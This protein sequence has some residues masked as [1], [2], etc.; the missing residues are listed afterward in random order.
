[1]NFC[2]KCGAKVVDE[3]DKFCGKCG[4]SLEPEKKEGEVGK[5]ATLEVKPEEIKEGESILID[6]SPEEI[7][8]TAYEKGFKHEEAVEIILKHKGYAT[9]RRKKIRGK[10]GVPYEIDIYAIKERKGYRS[11]IIV[12]CKNY[13]GPVPRKEVE[14]FWSRLQD[15]GKKTGLFVAEPRFSPDADQF[16]NAKGLELWGR[17][18]V[19]D[20]LYEVQIGRAGKIDFEKIKRNLPLNIDYDKATA[21]ELENKENIITENV[22]LIW[23]PYYIASYKVKCVRFDPRKRKHIVED[24][25]TFKIDGTSTKVIQQSSS[26]KTAF[27]KMVGTQSEEDTQLIK[28][29]DVVLKE[30]EKATETGISMVKQDKFEIKVL[31]PV[32]TMEQIEK[33]LI[34]YVRQEPYIVNYKLKR[35]EDNIFADE[36]E[37]PIT[38]SPKEIKTSIKMVYVPKWEMEFQSKEYSYTRILTGNTGTVIHDTISNCNKHWNLGFSKKRNIA[39]CDVCGEALCKEHIWKCLKCGTW[40]CEAH[41][42]TCISC[43]AKYCPEHIPLKCSICYESVCDICATT[44]AICGK[45]HC[46]KHVSRCSKCERMVCVDCSVK[47]GGILKIGQKVYCKECRQ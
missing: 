15:L 34:K 21:L 24:E 19:K 17:E 47:E 23:K 37:Y 40:R 33:K 35:D 39:V 43:K 32:E 2:R 41:I 36:R 12:E 44:C 38:P 28:E 5:N 46:K 8:S 11:E 9:E 16:G 1:M 26:L 10:T 20:K 7:E 25:G 18:T 3:S 31:P 4:A 30:L 27:M 45:T 14:S 13:S 6:I 42:I 29:H 22:K